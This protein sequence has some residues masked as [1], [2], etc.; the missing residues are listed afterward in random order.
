MFDRITIQNLRGIKSLFI[1]NIK[2]VN[3]F[4][5]RNNCGKT[6]ILEAIFLITGMSN[7]QLSIN[8][9]GFRNL[10]F[11]EDNDFSYLFRNFD[12][13]HPPQMTAQLSSQKRSLT[14]K[15][16]TTTYSQS[17]IENSIEPNV[18]PN[19]VHGQPTSTTNH[20]SPENRSNSKF[21]IKNSKYKR[22]ISSNA[23]T[24]SGDDIEGLEFDF[25]I[26][27]TQRFNT[28]IRLKQG[29][30]KFTKGYK[31]IL[32]A[33]FI[34]PE[35]IMKDID[36][37]LD[38]ILVK[39][40]LEQ[41]VNALKEIEPALVD[42]RMG[43]RGMVYADIGIEQLLPLNIMG[44]GIRRLLAILAAI[45]ERKNGILLIDEIENGLHYSTLEG[46]WKTI[47]RLAHDNHV[48]LF[49]TTHSFE[50]VEALASAFEKKQN[51]S[52]SFNNDLVSLYRI[53]R[54]KHGEHK[55]FQYEIDTLI[56]GIEKGF[57]VR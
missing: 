50:C 39:K 20:D 36:R 11:T 27:D 54:D 45:L 34:N 46:M 14:I 31:E 52:T 51:R 19:N 40:N 6:S 26:D 23:V 9:H 30:I 47:L 13:Q 5:G 4:T 18:L 12:L 2:Q 7:P 1:D 10:L 53:E 21:H 42:I 38:A 33:T 48:Q 44:D 28:E 25:T 22:P 17:F 57:E 16:I 43:A 24:D 32:N 56:A 55:A 3:L 8:I 41:I 35:T 37:R 29:A 15:G 49:I